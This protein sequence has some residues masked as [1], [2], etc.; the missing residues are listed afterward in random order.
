MPP[1]GY[2]FTWTVEHIHEN[3]DAQ[4]AAA[5]ECR[6]LGLDEAHDFAICGSEDQ[7]IAPL[8]GA[9]RITKEGDHPDRQDDPD[10]QAIHQIA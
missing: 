6:L 1:A 5:E 10:T 3:R 8:A 2:R 9:L 4:R 7:A